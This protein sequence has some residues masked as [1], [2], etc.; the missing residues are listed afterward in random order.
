MPAVY[1][2]ST[3][4]NQKMTFTGTGDSLSITW[5]Q[6]YFV[7]VSGVTPSTVSAY[8]VLTA[9]GI[10]VV[11]RSVYYDGTNIIPF[12]VCRDKTAEQ[13]TERLA[14]WKV[15]TKWA[16][17]N[18]SN[19]S[20]SENAPITP[21][22][23]LTDITPRVV[24][25]LGEI[26][27][28]LLADYS[29]DTKSCEISP[30]GTRWPDPI[31]ER[32]PTLQLQITQYESSITYEQMLERKFKVNQNDY[33]SKSR[34]KWLITQVEAIEVDVQLSGGETTAAQVTYTLNLS[35][36]EFGWK[37]RISLIDTHYIENGKRKQFLDEMEPTTGYITITGEKRTSQSGEPNYIEYEPF[38]DI[39]FGDFLQV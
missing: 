2:V 7:D 36:D 12:V 37:D 8:D 23:A 27:R 20:E 17:S 19:T 6:D 29:A 32:V 5:N 1:T 4:R 24:S 16:S 34:Y 22:A 11:N 15:S 28:P 14:R 21:P 3:G 31:M 33:R 9:T 25:S 30:S 10:P 35:P 39:D 26:E 18:K 13:M 38:D